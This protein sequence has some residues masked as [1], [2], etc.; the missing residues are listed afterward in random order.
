MN[1]GQSRQLFPNPGVFSHEKF[2]FYVARYLYISLE[3][4]GISFE[5][6]S[7][8]PGLCIFGLLVF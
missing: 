2:I 8:R 1:L 6:Q 4:R 7:S 5:F 3:P